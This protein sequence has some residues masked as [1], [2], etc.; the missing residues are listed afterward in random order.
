MEKRANPC[1]YAV[2]L[3]FPTE[4]SLDFSDNRGGLN[5]SMQLQLIQIF[6]PRVV[7]PQEK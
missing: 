7:G 5:G 4:T 2:I 6:S 3:A 1:F